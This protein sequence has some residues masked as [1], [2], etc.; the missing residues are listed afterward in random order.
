MGCSC[1]GKQTSTPPR[2]SQAA[3]AA[4]DRAK[5]VAEARAANPSVSRIGPA[6]SQAGQSQSFTLQVGGRVQTF[7]SALERD[8]AAARLTRVN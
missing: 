6:P 2:G 7:G 8:A 3:Q 1:G 5:A 4:A